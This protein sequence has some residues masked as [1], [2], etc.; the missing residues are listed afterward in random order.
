MGSTRLPG[1][2]VIPFFQK[3]GILE[4]LVG[5]ILDE[6]INVP[7]VIATSI[8]EKD[9]SI[10]AIGKNHNVSV[11]RGSEENVL[12]RFIGAARENGFKK[13]IRVCADNP[14]LD[15]KALQWQI[16]RFQKSNFD[17]ACYCLE[18][19]TPTIKT[20]YGFWTE[21]VKLTA[22]AKVNRDTNERFFQEHVTS[23]IYSFPENFKIDF[24][25]IDSEV[26]EAASI[27][28]T[29]DTKE[30]FEIAKRIYLDLDNN[31][32]SFTALNIIRSI[33][34]N[35]EWLKHMKLQIQKNT[36]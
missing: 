21:A 5:R 15:M 27:R 7:L 23:Y 13:I 25:R 31:Q 10:A 22:L 19:Q 11:Y 20:H 8:S 3:K 16:N 9:D 1:K 35:D 17:Y 6:I 24:S 4:V 28:L 18:D 34:K 26:E 29:V 14:F 30:D 36:K 2:M 33:K 12:E 32:T